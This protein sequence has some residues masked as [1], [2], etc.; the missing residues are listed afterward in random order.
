MKVLLADDDPVFRRMLGAMLQKWGHEIVVARDGEEAW[1]ALHAPEAPRLVVLNW[2]MPNMEGIEICRKLRQEAG[3]EPV[4]LILLTARIRKEDV[5]E[6]L[7]AGADDYITKPFDSQE[8]LARLKVGERILELQRCLARRVRELE[9][10][11]GQVKHLRGL[12]PICA[13][14]HK[15][16]DDQNYW[17]SVEAYITAHSEARFSHG[18]CPDCLQKVV[19]RDTEKQAVSGER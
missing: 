2:M 13:W 3:P 1:K 18:I 6:G 4:Y 9:E 7:N 12:L 15:I 14:C 8:L 16:R 10:A 19:N 11:L 17:Q 5:V